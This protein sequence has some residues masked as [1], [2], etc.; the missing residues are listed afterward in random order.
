MTVQVKSD[1]L[2]VAA[3]KL[4]EEA[5]ESLRRAAEQLAVPEKQYGVAAAFDHYTT[6]AAYRAYAT[7]MEEE[8]RLLEQACR[9]LADALEQ[10]A[11][12]YDRADKASAHRVGGVR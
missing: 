6:A 1:H 11:G 9:Q 3:R 8:F 2:R 5:A 10:T 12:D 4:R 7:A